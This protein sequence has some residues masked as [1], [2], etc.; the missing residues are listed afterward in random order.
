V[1]ILVLLIALLATIV[2]LMVVFEKSLIFFPTKYPS[3]RWDTAALARGS[4][5]EIEDCS[6][7]SG[8]GVRLL[9]WWCRPEGAAP[10]APVLLFLHG[11][12]GNLSDRAEF[13]LELST[14]LGVEVFIVGYRGYG[15]SEGGPSE[16]GLFA[17]ARASWDYLVSERGVDP[18]RIVIFGKSLGGAVAVDLASKV[19]PAGLIVE[20]SFTSI[21]DMASRHYPFVPRGLIRTK[22]D[23]LSKIVGIAVPKLFIHSRMDEVVPYDL[24]RRLYEAASG[25]KTFYE[26]DGAGH[27]ETSLVGGSAYY[28]ALGDFV[29]LV[30]GE[31]VSPTVSR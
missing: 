17:D 29:G 15:R 27:N 28:R 30:V 12:A 18:S 14:R 7:E 16:H 1:K 11:N 8:G 10:D 19:E 23:S 21:P 3:G 31:S 9:S 2:V 4:G 6:Y 22:M 13:I 26:V 5:C 20:S 24:G 25:P